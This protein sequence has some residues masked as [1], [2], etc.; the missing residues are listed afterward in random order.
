MDGFRGKAGAAE[1]QDGRDVVHS[2][3]ALGR[4]EGEDCHG[5]AFHPGDVEDQFLIQALV[6]GSVLIPAAILFIGE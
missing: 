5:P 3:V 1:G 2:V 6:R 4:V